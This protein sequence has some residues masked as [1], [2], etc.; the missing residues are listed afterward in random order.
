M[1]GRRW[2]ASLFSV[3]TVTILAACTAEPEDPRPEQS[4]AALSSAD[5]IEPIYPRCSY[6]AC[7]P[8]PL[9]PTLVCEDGSTAG[10]KCRRVDG[11]C[12]WT[13]VDC[14]SGQ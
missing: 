14:P 1:T 12:A 13:F 10:M 11:R 4:E 8:R 9:A 6:R 5:D 7:G 3:S 2:Q